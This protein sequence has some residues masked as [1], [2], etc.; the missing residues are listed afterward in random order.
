MATDRENPALVHDL[1]EAAAHVAMNG[2]NRLAPMDRLD[3]YD[4]IAALDA[5]LEVR[6]QLDPFVVRLVLLPA[7]ERAAVVEVGRLA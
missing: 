4:L 2:L 3:V 1:A 7:D 5:R 6:V